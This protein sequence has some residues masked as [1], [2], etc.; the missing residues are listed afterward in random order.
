MFHFREMQSVQ[1]KYSAKTR[2]H[3]AYSM[4]SLVHVTG[5][6]YKRQE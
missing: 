3:P 1:Q 4:L 6:A 2:P 5:S